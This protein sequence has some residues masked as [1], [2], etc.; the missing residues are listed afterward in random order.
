MHDIRVSAGLNFASDILSEQ[1]QYCSDIWKFFRTF[2]QTLI[3]PPYTENA[4]CPSHNENMGSF[5]NISD[6]R[7]GLIDWLAFYLMRSLELADR[8]KW[9]GYFFL[10]LF[11]AAAR[12][13]SRGKWLF[14]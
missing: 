5:A 8:W 6:G 10:L 12:L 11:S 2:F 7:C 1:P 9:V 3:L 13:V 14:R 4:I